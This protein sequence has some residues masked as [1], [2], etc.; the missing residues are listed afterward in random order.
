MEQL[1]RDNQPLWAELAAVETRLRRNL[2]LLGALQARHATELFA[3]YARR[4][5]GADTQWRVD[6]GVLQRLQRLARGLLVPHGDWKGWMRW[7]REQWNNPSNTW[8]MWEWVGPEP[9]PHRRPLNIGSIR[10]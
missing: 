2:D 5:S 6:L 9:G 7:M 8:K 4:H 10:S 1:A 3:A